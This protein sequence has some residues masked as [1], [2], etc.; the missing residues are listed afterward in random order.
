MREY[1][2]FEWVAQRRASMRA[3]A[4]LASRPQRRGRS[5]T[6]EETRM[7]ERSALAAIKRRELEGR[8]VQTGPREYV[9]KG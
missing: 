5:R 9:L 8:L 1:D 7:L 2:Y 4:Q 6:A 3:L